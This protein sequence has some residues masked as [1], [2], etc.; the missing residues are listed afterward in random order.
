MGWS[1]S[2]LFSNDIV[3]MREKEYVGPVAEPL[4]V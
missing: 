4:L 2:I 1:A 3:E